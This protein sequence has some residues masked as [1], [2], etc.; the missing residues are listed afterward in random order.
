M[1]SSIADEAA[2]SLSCC[3]PGLVFTGVGVYQGKLALGLSH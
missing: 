3:C 1:T 2:N